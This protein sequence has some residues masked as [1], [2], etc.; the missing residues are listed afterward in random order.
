MTSAADWQSRTGAAWAAEWPRTDRS[1]AELDPVLLEAALDGLAPEAGVLDVGCGAG[2]TSLAIKAARPDC[3]VTGVDLSVDLIEAAQ[4][5]AAMMPEGKRPDFRIEDAA[6]AQS[7]AFDR[8]LSRHGVMFFADPVA[9]LARLRQRVAPGGAIAFTCFRERVANGWAT[10]PVAALG[11]A[12]S[13]PP[14]GLAGGPGPFAFAVEDEV[15]GLL[16]AAGWQAIESRAV[17]YRYRAGE[18]PRAV[19]DAVALFRRIGPAAPV[20]AAE[21]PERRAELTER[22]AALCAEQWRDGI[23]SFPAAAW[24]WVARN[25]A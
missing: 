24:L 14:D 16:T 19:E 9:A 3:T 5:R 4:A 23:V 2:A 21:P 12:G 10:M 13:P 11:G 22:L 20:L 25:P 8:I 6:S 18:G 1:F 15:R 17:D 7:G